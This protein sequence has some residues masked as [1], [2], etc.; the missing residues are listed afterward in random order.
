M[1]VANTAVDNL[2]PLDLRLEAI[3]SADPHDL[4]VRATDGVHLFSHAK[5]LKG[6]A[7]SLMEPSET[8][9]VCSG[10]DCRF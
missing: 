7:L 1:P 9:N 10:I 8:A 3:V 6:A 2:M 5:L 4:L